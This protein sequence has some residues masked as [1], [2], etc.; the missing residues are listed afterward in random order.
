MFGSRVVGVVS[1][2]VDDGSS[3]VV[4]SEGVVNSDI[5]VVGGGGVDDGSSQIVGGLVC[6]G[7]VLMME[8]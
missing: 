5:G 1:G 8:L 6:G 3:G 4:V 7:D 2:D